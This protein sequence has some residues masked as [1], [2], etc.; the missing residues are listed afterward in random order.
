MSK[1]SNWSKKK[2]NNQYGLKKSTRK[3]NVKVQSCDERD[4]EKEGKLGQKWIKWELPSIQLNDNLW[5]EKSQEFS[6]SEKQW[7]RKAA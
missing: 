1:K 6:A 4:M 2:K 3:H 5:K 7:Q